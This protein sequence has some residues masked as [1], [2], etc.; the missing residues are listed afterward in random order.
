MSNVDV[1]CRV[2]DDGYLLG[3]EL[4]SNPSAYD[5][6]FWSDSEEEGIVGTLEPETICV[7]VPE[8]IAA[9]LLVHGCPDQ[10]YSDGYEAWQEVLKNEVK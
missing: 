3:A 9:K 7:C 2:T 5:D 4:A 1:L 6:R 8:D 10:W